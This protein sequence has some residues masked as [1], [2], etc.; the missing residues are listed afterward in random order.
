M[1]MKTGW[2]TKQIDGV[3]EKLFSISHVKST[4]Y[5]YKEGITLDK[6]LIETEDFNQEAVTE[7]EI[8]PMILNKINE[9]ATTSAAS[10][11][12]LPFFIWCS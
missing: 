10:Y 3:K 2:L 4:Y 7:P 9:V 8:A 5:N 1:A 6:M 11:S 12:L